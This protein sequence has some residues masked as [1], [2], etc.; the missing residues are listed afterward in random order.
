MVLIWLVP[1]VLAYGMVFLASTVTDNPAKALAG[2]LGIFVA[3][4]FGTM[5]ID[6]VL[7]ELRVKFLVELLLRDL[8]FDDDGNIL[9]SAATFVSWGGC[10]SLASSR[11]PASPPKWRSQRGCERKVLVGVSCWAVEWF[12]SPCS[13]ESEMYQSTATQL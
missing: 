10:Y 12:Y 8:D 4:M 6:R 2:G 9:R 13:G 11:E 1:M 7:P 5:M 3:V